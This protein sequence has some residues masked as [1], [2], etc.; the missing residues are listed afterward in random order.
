MSVG[1]ESGNRHVIGSKELERPGVCGRSSASNTG[2]PRPNG[3]GWTRLAK[4]SILAQALSVRSARILLFLS[5]GAVACSSST[6]PAA[7]LTAGT[8]IVTGTFAFVPS[9]YSASAATSQA[10]PD[11]MRL[12]VTSLNGIDSCAT[13]QMSAGAGANIFQVLVTLDATGPQAQIAEGIHTLG[14]GW[15]ASYRFADV[16]CAAASEGAAIAGALQIDGVDTS[17]RGIAD[18]TFPT[19]RVITTF[20]APFCGSSTTSTGTACVSFPVCPSG[21]DV[22]TSSGPTETCNQIP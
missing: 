20:N 21:P 19:G 7:R 10:D 11:H 12:V 9:R 16:S 15:Q 1:G 2:H 13:I 18:M 22:D 14:D 8:A 3:S 5:C 4:A 17:I 6:D